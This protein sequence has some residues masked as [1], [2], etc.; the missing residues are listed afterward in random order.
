MRA[1]GFTYAL[2]G[3]VVDPETDP[4]GWTTPIS[5]EAILQT[6]ADTL[7]LSLT[8]SG[9]EGDAEAIELLRS[10]EVPLV[11]QQL[12]PMSPWSGPKVNK[13]LAE[14]VTKNV[15]AAQP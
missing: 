5:E 15:L 6:A 8:T 7:L 10:A 11:Q 12:L 1:L 14:S 9:F 2:L 4:G 3:G 13:Q